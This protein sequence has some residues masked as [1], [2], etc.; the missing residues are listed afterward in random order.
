LTPRRARPYHTALVSRL[1]A[2]RRVAAFCFLFAR[3]RWMPD[4]SPPME[5][6]LVSACLL[7]LRSRYDGEAKPRDDALEL[8]DGRVCVPVCPEQMGGLPTPRAK[9]HL[10]GGDGWAV[11]AGKAKVLSDS[12]QDVTPEF[13]R[14]AQ[15]CVKLAKLFSA[16][17]AYLKQRSPSCGWGVV[18]VDGKVCEGVGVAAAALE[19]AGVQ[20]VA[21]D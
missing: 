12:G 8:L 16:T 5:R 10:T 11:L 3:A 2:R 17:H 14:G 21:I 18:T 13:L 7:G 9:S 1:F 20:I 4:E 6:V 19:A 15:E